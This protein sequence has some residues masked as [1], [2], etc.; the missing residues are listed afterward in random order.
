MQRI[1]IDLYKTRNL[2]SGLGQFAFNFAETLVQK[3]IPGY[4]FDFLIPPGF[5]PGPWGQARLRPVSLRSRYFPF[6]NETADLWHSLDQFPSYFPNHRTKWVL[7]IHD[8]NFLLEKDRWKAHRY[9]KKLQHHV[10]RAV[11]LTVISDFTR[12][13]V[14]EN[15]KVQGKPIYRIYNGIRVSSFPGTEKPSFLDGD[16]FFFSIGIISAKKNFHVLVPMMKQFPGYTL[17]IAG[18]NSSDYAKDILRQA[19]EEGLSGK[20]ILPGKIKEVEKYWLYANCRAFFFPS[21]A[22]GFGMPVIE[23]ML[24]GKPVF[25]S[26]ATS[27]PEI[28]GDFVYYWPSFNPD[29]MSEVVRKELNAWDL[30]PGQ[31]SAAVLAHA[32][33]FGWEQ[34]IHDYLTMYRE[35]TRL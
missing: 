28:G 13:M 23:A 14:Q 22:E 3:E 15:L 25:V 4:E 35:V 10:D 19:D 16:S 31:R 17:V 32:Q 9:L 21:L 7:T 26:T 12:N 29:Q 34:C 5:P 11:A 1:L 27:L 6:L 20:V 8:L 33:K 2:N 30:H 18:D 24:Y